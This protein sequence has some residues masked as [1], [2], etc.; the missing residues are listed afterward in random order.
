[1]ETSFSGQF[2]SGFET[3]LLKAKTGLSPQPPNLLDNHVI[4]VKRRRL[5]CR[6]MYPKEG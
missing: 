2:E 3:C 5:A 4:K 6:G 1:M